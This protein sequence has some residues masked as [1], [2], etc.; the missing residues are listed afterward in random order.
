VSVKNGCVITSTVHTTTEEV[1]LN[2]PT[3][4]LE[5]IN[6]GENSDIVLLGATE[7]GRENED[8]SMSRGE[9]VLAKL[10]DEQLNQEEKKL[11]REI[12]FEYQDVF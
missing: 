11:L 8:Q 6:D 2:E 10:Q 9:I 7:R 12:C 1:E 5:K 4:K 3:V